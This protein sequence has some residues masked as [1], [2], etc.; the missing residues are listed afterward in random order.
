MHMIK[1]VPALLSITA[2]NRRHITHDITIIVRRTGI[3]NAEK[4]AAEKLQKIEE[5]TG[6][7]AYLRHALGVLC[8]DTEYNAAGRKAAREVS[9]HEEFHSKISESGLE[10]NGNRVPEVEE[11]AANA[12]EIT[13]ML[14]REA[15][16]SQREHRKYV[17]CAKHSVRF[18]FSLNRP[19]M[20]DLLIEAIDGLLRNGNGVMGGE[21]KPM[22]GSGLAAAMGYAPYYLF[23]RECMAV[24]RQWGL[25]DGE[26]VLI[27]AVAKDKETGP[28]AARRFLLSK[29]RPGVRESINDSYGVDLRGFRFRSL[30]SPDFQ[31]SIWYW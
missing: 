21:L 20:E 17:A 27:D 3:E 12:C 10:G 16:G 15:D 30:C 7:Y 26:K 1:Q 19:G 2:C 14:H 6:N 13:N 24:L 18:L 8:Q 29:L 22:A 25:Q 4:K 11:S 31:S 28:D 9:Y 23:Y 5:K